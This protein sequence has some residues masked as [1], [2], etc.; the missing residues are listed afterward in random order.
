[1]N[2]LIPQIRKSGGF[3]LMELM[4]VVVVVAILMAVA[5]PAYE[6]STQKAR[7]ADGKAALLGLQL[8]QEKFRANCRFYAGAVGNADVCG[9]D[10]ASSTVNY[11]GV[12]EE[13]YYTITVAAASG[14]AF[15]LSADPREGQARDTGCDPMQLQFPAASKTP[16]QCWD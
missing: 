2:E 9:T 4:I 11:P 3:S 1:M 14:N 13:G 5:V 8:A 6:N 7:R 15:T 10:A 16:A 12:S